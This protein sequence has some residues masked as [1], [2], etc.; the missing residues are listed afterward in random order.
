M[1]IIKGMRLFRY[2]QLNEQRWLY[3]KEI[4]KDYYNPINRVSRAQ[5]KAIKKR[6]SENN[7]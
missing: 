5:E 1:V 2:A 4:K 7:R 3:E 6:T